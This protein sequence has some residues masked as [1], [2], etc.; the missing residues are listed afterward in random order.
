[1]H[2]TQQTTLAARWRKRKIRTDSSQDGT[3]GG[4]ELCHCIARSC[5]Q[6]GPHVTG[7]DLGD[8]KSQPVALSRRQGLQ[9]FSCWGFLPKEFW[10]IFE[11]Y[12]H[13]RWST[14]MHVYIY[15]Y[16]CK[17]LYMI[18][19]IYIYMNIFIYTCIYIYLFEFIYIHVAY[20]YSFYMV[21]TKQYTDS[22][23][24][25]PKRRLFCLGGA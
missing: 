7:H 10:A 23:R 8:M 13:I 12:Y 2:N 9:V 14:C 11:A 20:T 6:Q 16:T 24:Q 25:P 22:T 19:Y 17:Y 5:Q 15:I 18:W 4:G 1:M 3:L 21:K